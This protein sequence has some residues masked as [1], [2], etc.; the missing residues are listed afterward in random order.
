[1]GGLADLMPAYDTGPMQPPFEPPVDTSPVS[2][3]LILTQLPSK[4]YNREFK[5]NLVCIRKRAME[6]DVIEM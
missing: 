6:P 3:Q 5:D 2:V 1:M 4:L